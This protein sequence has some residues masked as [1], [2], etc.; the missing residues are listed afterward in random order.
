[1][2]YERHFF[3]I[4]ISNLH[5]H[6][7][8]FGNTFAPSPITAMKQV[9]LKGETMRRLTLVGYFCLI[10]VLLFAICTR[11][12]N[13]QQ[14][15]FKQ[16]RKPNSLI[17]ASGQKQTTPEVKYKE[18]ASRPG[19]LKSGER[20]K[21]TAADAGKLKM[22]RRNPSVKVTKADRPANKQPDS[23][24]MEFSGGLDGAREAVSPREAFRPKQ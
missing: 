4:E 17:N 24:Q 10:A 11:Q 1:M 7:S 9:N 16:L 15:R 23:P 21:V 19:Q 14:K 13:A 20:I 8:L 22:V 6:Q 5:I 3:A 12:T 2:A 18:E